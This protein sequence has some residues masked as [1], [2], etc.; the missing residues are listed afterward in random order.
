M[1]AASRRVFARACVSVPCARLVRVH[2][3]RAASLS[4][5]SQELAL[6]AKLVAGGS[7][8]LSAG[9]RCAIADAQHA[10]RARPALSLSTRKRRRCAAVLAL[11]TPW[12]GYYY[13][14][15]TTLLVTIIRVVL[16]SAIGDTLVSLRINSVGCGAH[17]KNHTTRLGYLTASVLLLP[18]GRTAHSAT[19]GGAYVR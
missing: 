18:L 10:E 9:A 19:N 15:F 13:C 4:R 3:A 14:F 11:A 17:S 8:A 16:F 6:R 1:L 2:C 7:L 5:Q 12:L